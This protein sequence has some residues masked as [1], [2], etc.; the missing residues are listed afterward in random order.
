MASI[1]PVKIGNMALSHIGASSSV[2]SFTENSSEAKQ[3]KLWYDFSRRQAL[4]ALDWNF[5][6]KRQVLASHS[7][8]APGTWLYRYQYPTDCLSIREI[9]NP[10]GKGADAVAFEIESSEDGGTKTILTDLS[11]ATAIYTF[12]CTS[13]NLYSSM[14]IEALSYLLAHHIS[15]S[16]NGKKDLKLTMLETYVGVLRLAS[17]QNANER[18]DEP[19]RDAEWIRD[20]V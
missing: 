12:D 11:P 1:S 2:E 18:V 16:L 7:D 8:D 14:F 15:F 13:T 4:E 17:A 19:P 9:E 6:R 5:A 10:Y 3:L 20:R